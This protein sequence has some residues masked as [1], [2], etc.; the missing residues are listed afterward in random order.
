[1]SNKRPRVQT[2]RAPTQR[3]VGTNPKTGSS[4][5]YTLATNPV[6]PTQHA[7][8]TKS[9]A[10]APTQ[11]FAD[12]LDREFRWLA[13]WGTRMVTLDTG[14][15]SGG[16][17]GIRYHGTISLSLSILFHSLSLSLSLGPLDSLVH[18]PSVSV[19]VWQQN[20]RS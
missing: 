13:A 17:T 19:E 9:A 15:P 5:R 2:A 4:D 8:F 18:S 7:C 3:L 6:K 12:Y 11:Q 1:M 16:G 10:A 14:M 20:D